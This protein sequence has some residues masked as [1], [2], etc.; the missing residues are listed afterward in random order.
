MANTNDIVG[1]Y[2]VVSTTVM[3]TSSTFLTLHG[4]RPYNI[5]HR[6]S[7]GTLPENTVMAHQMAVQ[8]GRFNNLCLCFI[9]HLSVWLSMS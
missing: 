4:K 9:T 2:I 1:I 7:S 8:Q 5:A 3:M 6:G